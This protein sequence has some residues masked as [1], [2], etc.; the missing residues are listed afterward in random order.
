MSAASRPKILYSRQSP[1]GLLVADPPW[2]F[3]DK[4]PGEGRG[5]EKHYV[6]LNHEQVAIVAT[7]GRPERL[8]ARVRSVFSSLAPTDDDS[9]RVVHSAKPDEFYRLAER[10]YGGPRVELFARRRRD[11]WDCYGNELGAR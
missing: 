2:P 7:R 10:L 4:L 8:D 9:G 11:G 3:D 5:A 1:A 6:L